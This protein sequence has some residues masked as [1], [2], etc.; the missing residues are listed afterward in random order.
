VLFAG[1]ISH[2]LIA[3]LKSIRCAPLAGPSAALFGA[4]ARL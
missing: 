4:S 2:L 1:N 3:A